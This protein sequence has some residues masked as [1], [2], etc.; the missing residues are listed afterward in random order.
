MRAPITRNTAMRIFG[1]LLLMVRWTCWVTVTDHLVEAR[2][3]PT[4]RAVIPRPIVVSARERPWHWW[5]GFGGR[6]Y[7]RSKVGF[8]GT[9]R[10]VVEL[11]LSEPVEVRVLFRKHCTRF[12]VSVDDPAALIAALS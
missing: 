5:F 12:A 7:G 2:L 11:E 10:G 3:G 1:P 9:K 8:V 6:I 4:C